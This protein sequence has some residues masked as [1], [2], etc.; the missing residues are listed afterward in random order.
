MRYSE[1][2]PNI[3]LVE[4]CI[5]VASY[6]TYGTVG[7]IYFIIGVLLKKTLKNF[8]QYHIFMSI[9]LSLLIYILGFIFKILINILGAI[10]GIG[11]IFTSINFF[12]I[13]DWSVIGIFHFSL[14][15]LL[16]TSLLLYLSIGAIFSKKTYLPFFTD[17]INSNINR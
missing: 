2:S 14:I 3:S 15:N 13:R 17:V 16:I 10:P 11:F 4:K 12:F 9:F 6:F 5:A 1:Y 8:L 7:V